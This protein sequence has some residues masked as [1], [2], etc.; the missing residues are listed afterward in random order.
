[1]ASETEFDGERGTVVWETENGVIKLTFNEWR[2]IAK[3]YNDM[4]ENPYSKDNASPV[5]SEEKDSMLTSVLKG[6]WNTIPLHPSIIILS[7]VCWLVWYDVTVL[8]K[9]LYT[10]LFGS[11]L[12]EAM[13]LGIGLKG[14]HY[15]AIGLVALLVGVILFKR[16]RRR[17]QPEREPDSNYKEPI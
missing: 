14:I 2:Q 6:L 1:M 16:N 3:A 15:L 17:R 12:G 11:R 8:G 13:S 9:D 7:W 5:L 4:I 10:I